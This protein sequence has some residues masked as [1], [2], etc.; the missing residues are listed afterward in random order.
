M[1]DVQNVVKSY[2]DKLVLRGLSFQIGE[3]EVVGLLGLNG[4]GKTTT[5]NILTGFLSADS[6]TVRIGGHDIL[7]EPKAAKKLIGY[8]PEQFSF[9][10][11]MRV[12][13]YLRFCC[14]LKGV[15]AGKAEKEA[16]IASVCKRVGLEKMR[17]R[18]IRNLSKGYKQR[19]GFAQALIGDP[20]V[21]ILDEPTVGLD[22]SQIVEIRD[23]IKSAGRQS[24]VIV[25]SHI[26]SEIQA[27]CSRVLVIHGG[28][29]I[30]DGA[31]DQ[32]VKK[33]SAAHRVHTLARGDR[34]RIKKALLSAEGVISARCLG[35]KEPGAFEFSAEGKEG[36]DIRE[37]VS[38]AM[39]KADLPL[40]HA[41][42]HVQSLEEVFLRLVGGT[43]EKE[44]VHAG[45]M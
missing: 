34:E 26:L 43:A 38:R 41:Y 2:G 1:I 17:R 37:A 15:A 44:D 39:A 24:T 19:V 27:V 29:V 30:A 35:E 9:Y 6:G 22:P 40:L 42:N 14:D 32:L 20:K 33:L 16:H 12:S 4:A 5:M 8:L 45:R 23:L 3:G 28:R 13:E 31:T 21:L 10:P 25:S 11:E 18:M 36:S 7:S